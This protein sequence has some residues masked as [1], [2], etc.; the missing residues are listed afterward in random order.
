MK[1]AMIGIRGIPAS[2]SGFETAAEELSAGLAERGHEVTVYNRTKD[3]SY[4]WPRYRGAQL[5]RLPTW[6]SKHL[7]TIVH[8]FL[9]TMHVVTTR[10]EIVHYYGAGPGALSWLARLF[11]KKTVCSVDG[12]DW[13]RRKWGAFA[14]TYLRA[15]EALVTKTSDAV[16]TDSPVGEV[17]YREKYGLETSMIAYGAKVQR[18]EGTARLT[19]YG[20]EPRRYIL[21]VGR[22]VPEKNVHHLIEAFERLET[23]M[24]LVIVGDD[25]F[26]KEY[27][28]SLKSHAGPRIVVT[29]Y[30]SGEGCAE[31]QSNAYVFVLPA[32][33]GGRSPVLLEAMGFGNCVVVS[34][35]P[36]NLEAIGEAGVS[37]SVQEGA[38]DLAIKLD[39]LIAHP[40]LVAEYREKAQQHAARHYVWDEV[41]AQ[42]ERLYGR[43]LAV[44]APA[45]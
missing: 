14:R 45:Q 16:I 3:I 18:Q 25:P 4:G 1:I 28:D 27:V 42:H 22:L 12:L 32:E 23:D 31:L 17:Y 38:D 15:S 33:V 36:S 11:G 44:N 43:L 34:D 6:R 5:V 35:T 7:S 20:L 41:V 39:H 13:S 8:S 29:G 9:A 37:Y 10:A 30:L 2:Y 24:K 19:Q 40:E 21:F 26:E